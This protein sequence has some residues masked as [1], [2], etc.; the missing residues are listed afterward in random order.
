[1]RAA[2]SLQAR[3]AWP[4]VRFVSLPPPRVSSEMRQAAMQ[5]VLDAIKPE[6]LTCACTLYLIVAYTVYLRCALR[7]RA[8]ELPY[9]WAH[10]AHSPKRVSVSQIE[11]D[12]EEYA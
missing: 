11:C 3:L 5:E 7:G 8:R 9:L 2:P 10:R 1:M 4:D 12:A 6:Q